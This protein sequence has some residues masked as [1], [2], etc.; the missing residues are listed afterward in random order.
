MAPMNYEE[1]PWRQEVT[2]GGWTILSPP[3]A[4]FQN[5]GSKRKGGKARVKICP[6]AAA[7]LRIFQFK[8]SDIVQSHL[9]IHQCKLK[10]RAQ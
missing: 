10:M 4:L 2:Q 6:T 8:D 3:D 7:L 5:W 1:N 9:K